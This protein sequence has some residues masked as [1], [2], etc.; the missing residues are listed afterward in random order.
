MPN[1]HDDEHPPWATVRLQES[2]Q[3]LAPAGAAVLRRP[4][5]EPKR[6]RQVPGSH[7]PLRFMPRRVLFMSAQPSHNR[8]ASTKQFPHGSC[9]S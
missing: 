7:C 2:R 9:S 8:S 6:E 3:M 1:K 4:R 5:H